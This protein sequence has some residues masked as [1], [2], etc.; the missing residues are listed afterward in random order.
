MDGLDDL[1][2]LDDLRC[3]EVRRSRFGIGGLFQA[4][5]PYEL[6]DSTSPRCL[7]CLGTADE[8]DDVVGA[9]VLWRG[10]GRGEDGEIVYREG[11]P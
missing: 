11:G 1:D 2:D 7:D 10:A 4:G 8:V 3:A 9:A 5:E 6:C